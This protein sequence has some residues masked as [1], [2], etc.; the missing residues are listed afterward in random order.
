MSG[1]RGG[2]WHCT[3]WTGSRPVNSLVRC[4][5]PQVLITQWG[6]ILPKDTAIREGAWKLDHR[7]GLTL[8]LTSKVLIVMAF[9]PKYRVNGPLFW[10]RW[11]FRWDRDEGQVGEANCNSNPA[12]SPATGSH[13]PGVSANA[14]RS[15]INTM[16]NCC[17]GQTNMNIYVYIHI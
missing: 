1:S 2:N 13:G 5:L 16:L 4:T 15:I 10:V 8:A 17:W 6:I 9:V 12:K 3:A 11:R 14:F 7:C